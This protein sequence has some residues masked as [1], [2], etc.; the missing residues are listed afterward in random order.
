MSPVAP[1]AQSV[2]GKAVLFFVGTLDQADTQPLTRV[3]PDDRC[4]GIALV[5]REV[6]VRAHCRTEPRGWI[7]PAE[8]HRGTS[9]VYPH[10]PPGGSCPIELKAGSAPC[11]GNS[12]SARNRQRQG[13]LRDKVAGC[14]LRAGRSPPAAPPRPQRFDRRAFAKRNRGVAP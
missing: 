4:I 7:L 13:M 14:C 9:I 8:A 11:A 6:L 3:G 12:T 1:P 10:R 5:T 2:G